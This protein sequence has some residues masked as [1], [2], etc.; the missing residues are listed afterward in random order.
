MKPI[1]VQLRHRTANCP[2]QLP[3]N[4]SRSEDTHFSSF[5]FGD[6]TLGGQPQ[7]LA[8]AIAT[9]IAS[10]PARSCHNGNRSG[11]PSYILA[12]RSLA[13]AS[14]VVGTSLHGLLP[15]ALVYL[16]LFSVPLVFATG[17]AAN[18]RPPTI[19]CRSSGGTRGTCLNLWVHLVPPEN[20]YNPG[21]SRLIALLQGPSAEPT[22][23]NV[24]LSSLSGELLLEQTLPAERV[25]VW[26]LA[27]PKPVRQAFG[28]P[29]LWES[30]PSCRP[31]KPPAR[32]LLEFRTDGKGAASP[33]AGL[34]ESCG[35][36]VSS[37][38]LLQAFGL[39]E[40][41]DK[42]PASLPLRC[43]SLTAGQVLSPLRPGNAASP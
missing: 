23:M 43:L 25:A 21:P 19:C 42:L 31:N 37:A 4:S 6:C 34:R 27:L 18:Q 3:S 2:R 36:S 9:V 8:I 24:Q 1:T 41:S 33:L 14:S 5:N 10:A 35:E 15:V 29:L 40:W 22:S 26:L 39:D 32:T 20:R 17:A 11:W 13:Q 7:S 30:Y 28:Q 16:F 38:P 12:V